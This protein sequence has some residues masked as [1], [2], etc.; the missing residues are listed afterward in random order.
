MPNLLLNS[1]EMTRKSIGTNAFYVWVQPVY[2]V[3]SR[4][5]DRLNFQAYALVN[6]CSYTQTD[7]VLFTCLSPVLHTLHTPY[8]NNIEKEEE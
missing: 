7:F 8:I 3:V 5:F 2:A 4:L 6:P 1:V